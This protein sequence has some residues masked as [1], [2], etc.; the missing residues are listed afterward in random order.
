MVKIIYGINRADKTSL[1]YERMSLDINKGKKVIL[2]VPEQTVLESERVLSQSGIISL[3]MQVV[4]FRRLSNLVFRKY[5]GLCYNYISKQGKLIVMWR[6]LTEL[7][8][9]LKKYAEGAE[10]ESG[11]LP[12][13][14]SAVEEFT[15]NS[16][17]P[18]ALALAAGQIEDRELS[19][20]RVSLYE[21]YALL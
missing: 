4:S 13:L 5:G 12:L 14:C 3:D 21:N 18:D 9:M 10:K 1:V 19:E 8:P 20:S 11:L 2:L 17:T 6:A 15:V 7:S 16:I